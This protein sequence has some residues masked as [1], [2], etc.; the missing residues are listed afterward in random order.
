[1]AMSNAEKK[2]AQRAR[3]EAELNAMEDSS[4]PF[5]K[6]PFFQWLERTEGRGDW[7]AAEMDLN[8]ASLDM[9]EFEDDGGPRPFDDAFGDALEEY[10]QGY[11]GSIGRAEAMVDNLIGAASCIALVINHYKKDELNARKDE[12]ENA[13]LADPEDRKRAFEEVVRIE[14]ML[15]RLSKTRR[16]TFQEWSL[17]GV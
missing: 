2:R 14:K 3:Q 15:D 1:M 7:T 6:E 4:Y 17:K 10:Y 5:L 12:L 9:P 11:K 13:D 8:L 16:I